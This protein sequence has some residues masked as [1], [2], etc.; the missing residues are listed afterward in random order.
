MKIVQSENIKHLR[1]DVSPSLHAFEPEHLDE[2]LK[3]NCES[4]KINDNPKER[5]LRITFHLNLIFNLNND[6]V[7]G[8]LAEKKLRVILED[9]ES[10]LRD[11]EAIFEDFV[12]N[13][14]M[15]I[16]DNSSTYMKANPNLKELSES[17]IQDFVEHGYYL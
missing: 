7:F 3:M 2:Q 15:H 11:I 8:Y 12:L 13:V 10:D 14:S 5:I 9:K 1:I 6:E 16:Q 17:T 4:S